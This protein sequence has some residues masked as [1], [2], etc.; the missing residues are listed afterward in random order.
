MDADNL[1]LSALKKADRDGAVVLRVFEIRGDTAEGPV[2]FLGRERSFR[3]VN[4]LEE[5]LPTGQLNVLHV[6]PYEIGTIKF[7]AR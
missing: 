5:N 3:A 2:R 1:V 7:S 6:Q 4:L